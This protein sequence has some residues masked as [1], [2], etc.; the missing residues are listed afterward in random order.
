[1]LPRSPSAVPSGAPNCV[2]ANIT[3]TT[4]TTTTSTATTTAGTGTDCPRYE[5][6][7]APRGPIP[8]GAMA[9]ILSAKARLEPSSDVQSSS[10]TYSATTTISNGTDCPTREATTVP[11]AIPSRSM[12]T[13]LAAK[14][15]LQAV[16]DTESSTSSHDSDS[17]SARNSSARN[18]QR[19]PQPRAST[20]ERIITSILVR[21]LTAIDHEAG[22]RCEPGG[23]LPRKR[24]GSEL[25]DCI[26]EK[27]RRLESYDDAAPV[28]PPEWSSDRSRR[29]HLYWGSIRYGTCDIVPLTP[30]LYAVQ[31]WNDASNCP[32]VRIRRIMSLDGGLPSR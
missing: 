15:G 14:A 16:S 17:T 18:A 23:L 22:L 31:C 19:L 6:T 27:R 7:S 10:S 2:T 12:A 5:A 32:E 25:M 26:L 28:A 11:R 4:T 1:M 21:E 30:Q 29:L 24:S 3:T 13:I 8:R 20:S 9:N